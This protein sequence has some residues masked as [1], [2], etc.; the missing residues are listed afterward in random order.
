MEGYQ[1]DAYEV[2]L[3]FLKMALAFIGGVGDFE[4][5]V[6]LTDGGAGFDCD[7]DWHCLKGRQWLLGLGWTWWFILERIVL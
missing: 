3:Y 6:G 5:V 2:N 4:L 1:L 7:V